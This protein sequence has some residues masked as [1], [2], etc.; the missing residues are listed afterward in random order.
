MKTFLVEYRAKAPGARDWVPQTTEVK[1]DSAEYAKLAV[2]G[3][4]VR[5]YRVGSWFADWRIDRAT[6]VLR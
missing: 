5:A 6:E 1:G 2:Q 4:L 3:M